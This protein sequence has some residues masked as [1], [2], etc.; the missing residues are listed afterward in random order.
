MGKLEK[1]QEL[2]KN[3]RHLLRRRV[4]CRAPLEP[5][6]WTHSLQ[7]YDLR[8]I[9]AVIMAADTFAA[10]LSQCSRPR[11]ERLRQGRVLIIGAGR[12]RF[13]Q[14]IANRATGL[15]AVASR[16]RTCGPRQKE[17]VQKSGADAF[18]ELPI[19]AKDGAGD[20]RGYATAQGRRIFNIQSRRELLG[21]AG[22]GQANGRDYRRRDTRQKITG[23]RDG[24][25]GWHAWLRAPFHR[26]SRRRG[27]A[28]KL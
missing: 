9:K 7:W 14:A 13:L 4:D 20:A 8:I 17:Q 18:L 19:E 1:L 10:H 21:G 22:G 25:H 5:R 23:P 26:G 24:G 28:G 3:R 16:V 15:G 27:A 6:A 2:A 12:S 11:Q